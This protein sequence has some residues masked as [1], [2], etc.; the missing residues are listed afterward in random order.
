[1][2][3]KH[4]TEHH[5]DPVNGEDL[6]IEDLVDLKFA[7]IDTPATPDQTSIPAKLRSLQNDWDAFSRQSLEY[8]KSLHQTRQELATALYQHDA[9]IRVITRLT[10]ERD[11]A[12]DALSKVSI[13][14]RVASDGDAM[15]I[16]NQSLPDELVAKVDAAQ[17]K[18]GRRCTYYIKIITNTM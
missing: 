1:M 4:I 18:Y 14:A 12:R 2:I 5:N 8:Q 6:E 16:D 10:R 13:G 9:A 7:P 15:Q 11:E 3:E 17:E